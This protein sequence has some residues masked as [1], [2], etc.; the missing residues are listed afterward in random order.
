M[1]NSDRHRSVFRCVHAGY[2]ETVNEN[3]AVEIEKL[4]LV[5]KSSV[6]K[7]VAYCRILARRGRNVERSG[8]VRRSL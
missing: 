8:N 6:D 4:P 2:A 5:G 1:R 3:L 7:R